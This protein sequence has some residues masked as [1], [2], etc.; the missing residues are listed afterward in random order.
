LPFFKKN[1]FAAAFGSKFAEPSFSVQINQE[2]QAGN[3]SATPTEWRLE[4]KYCHVFN[5]KLSS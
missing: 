5:L 4:G 3:K 2:P 1:Y